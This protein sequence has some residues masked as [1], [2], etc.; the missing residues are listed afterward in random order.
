V[1]QISAEPQ[2]FNAAGRTHF[3]L[4]SSQARNNNMAAATIGQ[5]QEML[6]SARGSHVL[7]CRSARHNGKTR[8]IDAEKCIAFVLPARAR[9]RREIS[10]SQKS[11]KG[12]PDLHDGGPTSLSVAYLLVECTLYWSCHFCSVCCLKM[13]KKNAPTGR[14]DC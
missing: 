2:T 3:D 6:L 9:R 7:S 13:K 8:C 4:H 14:R 1:C 10:F 5:K 11:D 12:K